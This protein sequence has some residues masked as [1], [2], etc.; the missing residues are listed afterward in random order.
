MLSAGSR[1]NQ[2]ALKAAFH[3]GLNPEVLTEL[4]RHNDRI[5]R[6]MLVDLAIHLDQLICNYQA[7]QGVAS[8]IP[9]FDYPSTMLEIPKEYHKFVEVFSKTK[10]ISLPRHRSYDYAIDLLPG[11]MLPFNCIYPLSLTE[12]QVMKNY[13]QVLIFTHPPLLPQQASLWR[14]KGKDFIRAL[15]CG[16]NQIAVKYPYP[17]PLVPS[18]LEQLQSAR[19]LTKLDLCSAYNLMHIRKGDNW[20]MAFRSTSGHFKYCVMPFGLSCTPTVF[21][22]LINYVV[23]DILGKFVMAY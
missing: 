15:T 3:Q 21:Q 16:L 1:W 19:L 14:K 10:A 17:L 9:M 7:Y 12:Q 13:L 23:S 11:T 8:P 20:K 22:C 4:A 2:Q 5:A 18:A 6:D